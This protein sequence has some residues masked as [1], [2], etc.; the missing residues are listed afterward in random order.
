M[1]THHRH[2]FK[3]VF[4][5]TM[6]HSL[7]EDMNH[8]IG[9]SNQQE[10]RCSSKTASSRLSWYQNNYCLPLSARVVF[11]M[12]WRTRIF[13]LDHDV[14]RVYVT[15]SSR[16]WRYFSTSESEF[17]LSTGL[18]SIPFKVGCFEFDLKTEVAMTSL[19]LWKNFVSLL[20][21][22]VI[23]HA[24]AENVLY[25]ITE[26]SVRSRTTK[27]FVDDDVINGK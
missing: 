11:G 9:Q 16:N 23:V 14:R 17:V 13:K 3:T 24:L 19:H 7:P 4:V 15:R 20:Y 5:H 18:A 21:L 6:W 27:L 22:L 25:C 26:R 1:W 2:K 10:C 8:A 12:Q